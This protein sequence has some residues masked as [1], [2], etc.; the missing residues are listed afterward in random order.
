MAATRIAPQI[1]HGQWV[2]MVYQERMGSVSL[3]LFSSELVNNEA[4]SAII[5]III[6]KSV[7][8]YE[9]T[10]N[11]NGLTAKIDAISY[12]LWCPQIIL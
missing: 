2:N 3:L 12:R 4:K 5:H 9:R 10:F 1:A 6:I 7:R 8:E 11:T